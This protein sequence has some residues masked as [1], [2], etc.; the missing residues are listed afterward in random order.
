[1]SEKSYNKEENTLLVANTAQ[2]SNSFRLENG[3]YEENKKIEWVLEH[4][5]GYWGQNETQ[6]SEIAR[7]DWI[8]RNSGG[9][10][11]FSSG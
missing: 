10:W 2:Q 11:N 7:H 9:L 5:A 8:L 1:M 4:S 3:V 6:Q